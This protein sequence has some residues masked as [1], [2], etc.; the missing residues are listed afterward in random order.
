MG[1][2]HQG[3]LGRWRGVGRLLAL[4]LGAATS[5]A[6][7]ARA[8]SPVAIGAPITGEVVLNRDAEVRIGPS[9]DARIVLTLSKGKALNA[10]GTP[11]GTTWTQVAIGGQPLG[12]VPADA[13]DPV[14]VPRPPPAP[15][16]APAAGAAAVRTA[17]LVTRAEWDAA[18]AGAG[19]AAK[20]YVVATK[21]I[22]ATEIL[23]GRK[24]RSITLRRGQVAGIAAVE[25]GRADLLVPGRERVVVALDGLM[26]VAAAYPLPGQPAIGTGP[27][28]VMRFGEFVSYEEGVRAWQSFTAGP[29]QQWR[30]LPPVVWPVFR[31]G[32]AFYQMGVG[33]FTGVE[34][35]RACV[36]LAQRALDCTPLELQTF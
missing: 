17:A 15:A 33:P 8:Q 19:A 20:G 22:S 14:Y 7:P 5:A 2:L 9:E 6:L 36:A 10:L 34:L 30:D 4:L 1:M 31:G 24:Q 26:G 27:A 12:Y 32:R 18:V 29:G 16:A 23:S 21:V 25:N 35:D 13:L 11:R 28:Y 3:R